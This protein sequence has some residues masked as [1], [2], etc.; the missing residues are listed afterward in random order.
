MQ[1]GQDRAEFSVTFLQL[2][3]FGKYNLEAHSTGWS[4]LWEPHGLVEVSLQILMIIEWNGDGS[5]WHVSTQSF[6]YHFLLFTRLR[7]KL[8]FRFLG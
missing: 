3:V 8:D 5:A 7:D 2:S 1:L 6:V 4:Q